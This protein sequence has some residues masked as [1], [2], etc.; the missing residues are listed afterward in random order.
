HAI[1]ITDTVAE[2][3]AA[4]RSQWVEDGG[5]S[6]LLI[7]SAIVHGVA[8]VTCCLGVGDLEVV[9]GRI[10]HHALHPLNAHGCL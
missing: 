4:L 3:A 7:R 2:A 10:D 9:S 1:V 8:G 6:E 5:S